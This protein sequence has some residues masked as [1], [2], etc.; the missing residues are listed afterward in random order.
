MKLKKFEG[1]IVDFLK[2][3]PNVVYVLVGDKGDIN[4]VWSFRWDG[5]FGKGY[6]Q[7]TANGRRHPKGN[8][9]TCTQIYSDLQ[10]IRCKVEE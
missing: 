1:N 3:T 4:Q 5:I 7:L 6:Y 8:F 10:R 9:R 2:A